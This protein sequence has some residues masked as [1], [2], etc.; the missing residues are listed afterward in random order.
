MFKGFYNLTSGMLTQGRNLDVISNNITN[1]GTVG[2]K[3][4]KFTASTFDEAM[5]ARVGNKQKT[6]TDI[7]RQSYILAPSEQYTDYGQGAFDETNLPLDF[8]IEGYGY[9]AVETADGRAY[10]RAGNFTLDN[11]G[12]LSLP[13]QGRVLDTN[14]EPILMVSDKI[15]ADTSG[16]LYY[17]DGGDMFARIG[18]YAFADEAQLRKNAQGLFVSDAQ[19]ALTQSIV[20]NGMLERSNVDMVKQMVEMMASQRAY[21]SAAQV[22]KMYDQLMTKATNDIGRL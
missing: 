6:Y 3:G 2:F 14:G 7:G 1:V 20:R 5:W 13:G 10:T 15:R 16:G 18:V 11:E 19:P 17:E 12:Y 21:Q 9:F 8:A 4:D 22:S